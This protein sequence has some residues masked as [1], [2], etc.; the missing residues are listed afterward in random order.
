[1]RTQHISDFKLFTSFP[2]C[3]LFC[4]F[5]LLRNFY[6]GYAHHANNGEHCSSPHFRYCTH[7]VDE[8]YQCFHTFRNCCLFSTFGLIRNFYSGGAP[9]ANYGKHSLNHHSQHCAHCVYD[10]YSILK[11]F[12]IAVYFAH[13]GLI[14]NFYSGDE[15]HVNYD[16]HSLNHH[17]QN[18]A[19][20]VYEIYSVFELV[21]IAVCFAHFGFFEI[22]TPLILAMVAMVNVVQILISNIAHGVYMR[23]TVFSKFSKLLFVVHIF[24]FSTFELR[25]F[26]PFCNPGQNLLSH[27]LILSIFRNIISHTFRITSRRS[28]NDFFLTPSPRFN[29]GSAIKRPTNEFRPELSVDQHWM[30]GSGDVSAILSGIVAMVNVVQIIISNIAHSVYM[31]FT[32]F[33]KFSKLLF[34]LQIL[35]YSKFLLRW[36]A[37]C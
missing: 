1:M 28:R 5:F 8:I 17:F 25:R 14:G 12:E 7:S 36:G 15:Q 16:K 32:V 20:Y 31:R 24:V 37:S 34:V 23:F 21:E 22:W 13:I 9:Q 10:I 27:A 2:N 26:S 3:N 18:C 29:V 6:F 19:H 11:V 33:S 4:T 35:A 30:G